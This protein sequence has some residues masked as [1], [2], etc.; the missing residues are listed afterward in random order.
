[1]VT[2]TEGEPKQGNDAVIRQRRCLAWVLSLFVLVATLPACRVGQGGTPS[3]SGDDLVSID[4]RLNALHP[5]LTGFPPMVSSAR[6]GQVVESEWKDL[7][8]DLLAVAQA[9]PNDAGIQW[10]LGVLY[11]YGHNL[12]IPKAAERCIV[13]LKR[14]IELRRDFPAAYLELGI[15]YTD[16]GLQWAPLGEANLKKA[17]ELSG[18]NP[19]P[20]AWRA[21]SFA[22]YY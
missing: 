22:Y 10:R 3:A 21:L 13:H 17:I 16:S 4:A 5:V 19:I 12:D 8:S 11:R 20:R 2:S 18:A 7:E 14:A 9:A 1:M 15:F 6:E